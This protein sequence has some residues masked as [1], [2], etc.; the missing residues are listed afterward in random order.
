MRSGESAPNS[1]CMSYSV[2]NYLLL[3]SL[4]LLGCANAEESKKKAELNKSKLV[5]EKNEVQ[6]VVLERAPFSK[7]LVSN[8]RLQALQKTVLSFEIGGKLGRLS[9]K[10]GDRVPKGKLLASLDQEKFR[11]KLKSSE[12]S[13]R[14]ASIDREDQLVV[15]GYSLGEME[16][17]PAKIKEIVGVKSGYQEAKLRV[18]EAERELEKS[19]L[20]APF[21]GEAANLKLK[22][23]DQV[24][25]G[26]A[27]LTLIDDRQFEVEFSLIES[28]YQD[29]ALGDEVRLKPFALD[30]EYTGKVSAINPQVDRNGTIAVKALVKNDG[31]LLEG[32]NVKIRMQKNLGERFVVPKSSVVIR[33]DQEVLFKVQ[34]GKAYWTYVKIVSENSHSY[35]VIPHPDKSSARLDVGDSIITKGN[36][37]LAH[38]SFVEV[39]K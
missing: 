4:V 33:Q 39:K 2:K 27:F 13:L 15:R 19:E 30:K 22:V 9:V 7:E 35:A 37:N 24:S 16:K 29:I 34:D 3:V 8:G 36:L 11:R 20:H 21:A 31:K 26:R 38:E 6:V 23:Y 10:N 1:I 12:L 18:E 17:V 5:A 32:M 28:E 25:P 14:K